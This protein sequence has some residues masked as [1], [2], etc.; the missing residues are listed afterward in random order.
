MKDQIFR[1]KSS[2]NKKG[3]RNSHKEQM[4]DFQQVNS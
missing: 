3:K 2:N 1:V 4:D